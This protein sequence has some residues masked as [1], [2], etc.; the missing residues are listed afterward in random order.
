MEEKILSLFQF[1]IEL[2][3]LKQRSIIHIRDYRWSLA[4]DEL[5]ED[6]EHVTVSYP[7]RV[8]EEDFESDRILL[9]VKKPEFALCPRPPFALREWLE[10][11]WEDYHTDAVCYDY[12]ERD[13]LVDHH[14]LVFTEREDQEAYDHTEYFF[15]QEG[16]VRVFENWNRERKAWVEEQKRVAAERDLFMTLYQLYQDLLR[17]SETMEIVAANGFIR[18]RENE[19]LDHPVITRR[20]RLEYDPSENV[21]LIRDTDVP[22]EL[23]SVVFQEMQEINRGAL[24]SLTAQLKE[25]DYH[26]MDRNALPE[27]LKILIHQIS[28][29][30]LFLPLSQE[31][32]KKILKEASWKKNNRFVLYTRSVF[33]LRKK[34]DGAGKAMER[35]IEAIKQGGEIPDPIRDLVCGGVIELPEEL[36]SVSLEERLAAVGGESFEILLAKEANKEQLDIAK[37]IENFNAVL[38]QGPPG[39]GKTHTIANLM[40]HFLAQGK[41]ILVTSHTKKALDVMKDKLP[42]GLRDL[43]V[44]VLEDSSHDMEKSIDGITSRMSQTNSMELA[45]AGRE[46]EKERIELMKQLATLR[47][48]IY[49]IINQECHPFV[50]N[51]EEITPTAAAKFVFENQDRLNVIPGRTA[52]YKALP[53]SMEDILE[54]YRSN[55]LISR[56]EEQELIAEVPDPEHLLSPERFS[57]LVKETDAASAAMET[58]SAGQNLDA[59]FH[60]SMSEH[61]LRQLYEACYEQEAPAEWML[62]AAVDGKRGTAYQKRWN[63]L[64]DQID[65]TC[66][67]SEESMALLF[68]KQLSFSADT[69]FQTLLPAM[70]SIKQMLFEKGKISRLTLLMNKPIAQ[71]LNSVTLNQGRIAT[72]EECEITLAYLELMSMRQQCGAYWDELLGAFGAPRFAELDP[73]EPELVARKWIPHIAKYV[74]WFEVEY[75]R[76]TDLMYEL[77]LNPTAIFGISQLDTDQ[78]AIGK[79]FASLQDQVPRLCRYGLE[80]ARKRKA[81]Q[82]LETLIRN[83][84]EKEHAASA[85]RMN[86]VRAA[87]D[88]DEAAYRQNYDRVREIYTKYDA[89][90]ARQKA[91]SILSNY[92]PE[93]A[94]AIR[95]RNGIHGLE[96]PPENLQDAWRWKQFSGILEEMIAQPYAEIQK[97]CA[98]LGREYR[99]STAVY[100]ENRAWYHLLRRIEADTSLQQSLVGWKQ[101]IKRIGKG[102]GKNAPMWKAKAR[103][104]MAKCQNAVPAW[105]MPMGKALENLEPGKNQFDIIIID[106]ASQSDLTALALLYMGKKL[107]IVG[108]DRQVSPMAIGVEV[109]QMEALKQIYVNGKIPNAHLYDAKTSVYDIAATTFQPLMLR[110]HFRCVPDIIG[111]SNY[112]SYD[113][114]IKP[115]RDETGTV[116]YPSVISCRTEGRREGRE[117]QVEAETIIRI[118]GECMEKPEYEGKTFGI[119]SM[120]GDE[121]VKLI[122][123]LLF[124]AFDPKV[125]AER[126]ILCGN[127]ANFQGDERDVIFLSLVDSP[128]ENQTGALRVVT[129]G[130]DDSMRKRYNVAVSRARDQLWIVHSLDPVHDLKPEDIR[131]KLLDYAEKPEAFLPDAEGN[132]EEST[133]F[134]LEIAGKL[135][136]HGYQ[137]QVA[138]RVGDYVL[139]LVVQQGRKKVV[140][141]CDGETLRNSENRIRQDMERQAILERAGWNFIRVRGSEYYRNPEGALERVKRDLETLG[142]YQKAV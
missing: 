58:I 128:A 139:D 48:R 122:Q 127:S 57:E 91:L 13:Y 22:S 118:L 10:P 78:Q 136:E 123:R 133:E 52:L 111:F 35:V 12:L 43:C 103:E 14:E 99:S 42:E 124:E 23:Y 32:N 20:V 131:K 36:H 30:S 94:A 66:L 109:D 65:K 38:V 114:K 11:E 76:I 125:I 138:E 71:A 90:L 53:L 92:A 45:D 141:E 68:G 16:R 24:T 25:E 134:E 142:I 117:N 67:K 37:R 49:Q 9:A 15:E 95:S 132:R 104:L 116:L 107:I 64:M 40:G 137:V 130:A 100:A 3:K 73:V 113:G 39:T 27:F 8:S 98:A 75:T 96:V 33:L 106:E 50:W 72:L 28:S 81:Q 54:L 105:I 29:D 60:G 97:N 101:T 89:Q 120:L 19:E 55:A 62:R 47:N 41:N 112:L 17:D 74:S 34:L 31:E 121:Q 1:L 44:S 26:P 87:A 61:V 84:T 79:V 6:K 46:L 86:L 102:T 110:E 140:V 5:P 83:L 135:R 119:I 59:C 80:S 129:Y 70:Y 7:D 115:L 51:G 126:R 77:G 69:D 2:N 85:L 108:D 4:L 88:K 56:E 93:W 21:V 82:I 63:V 18:D